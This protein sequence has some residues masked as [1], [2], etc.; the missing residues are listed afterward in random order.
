MS[1]TQPDLL[2][3]SREWAESAG[4]N[5]ISSS[6]LLSGVNI[7]SKTGAGLVR[8]AFVKGEC[9]RMQLNLNVLLL[10]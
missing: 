2:R 7:A 1:L 4:L 6:V 9:T 10:Q 3:R 5:N 8:D